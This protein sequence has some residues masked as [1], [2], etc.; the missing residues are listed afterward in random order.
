[1]Q[2]WPSLSGTVRNCAGGSTPWGTWLSCE[3]V[4][5]AGPDTFGIKH[6]YCFE[7]APEGVLSN[8]PIALKQMGRFS[9]EAVTVDPATGIVYETEDAG[10]TSGFYR[11]VPNVPGQ[12]F[13][14]GTLQMLKAVGV[15]QYS[16]ITT[17]CTEQ[18][19]DV[20]WVTIANPDAPTGDSTQPEST[21]G[22]GSAL[23]G[24]AFNRLEGCWYG[25]GKIY[26]L[27]TSGGPV[28]EGQVFEYDPAANTLKLIYASP[29]QSECENPDNMTVT[30]RGGLL[31]CEDNSGSTSNPGERLLGLTLDGEIFTFALNNL[32]FTRT[33]I[34]PYT[35]PKSGITYSTNQVQNEWAG[36]CYSPDGQW[37]FANI[38][39]PGITFAIRP[40]SGDWGRGPL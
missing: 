30:P 20:E 21:F 19:W 3:E 40:I 27:S 14:G 18:V 4:S 26:F 9:H 34:G 23:G 12:L 8:F 1:V 33:G 32:N 28:S 16:F 38:Q 39:T 5:D 31:L 2:D 13:L 29:A 7:V 15:D 17:D 36:A 37:L 10:N 24:A 6:G 35:N 22:Q 25:M 11:Y